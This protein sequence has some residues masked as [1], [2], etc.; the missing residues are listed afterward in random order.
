MYPGEAE[1]S[2]VSKVTDFYIETKCCTFLLAFE[3]IY[4]CTVSTMS[5]NNAHLKNDLYTI[6]SD[7]HPC[8]YQHRQNSADVPEHWQ[9]FYQTAFWSLS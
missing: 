6:F 9:T 2:E 7:G 8:T 1:K 3:A 4:G 5:T